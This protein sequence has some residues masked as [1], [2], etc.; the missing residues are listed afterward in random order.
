M[1]NQNEVSLKNFIQI[2]TGVDPLPVLQQLFLNDDLWDQHRM[3]TTF[4]GTPHIDVSDILLRFSPPSI[5]KREGMYDNTQP[6]W[7]A[8]TLA[9][10]PAVRPIVLAL[11]GRVGAFELG[12]TLI[13]KIKPGGQ[14][15]PHV[16]DE[17][18]YVH[19]PNIMR[20][21]VVLQGLP[22]SLFH[23]GDE[24]VC[25]KT[26]EVWAFNAHV[27]HAVVNNSADDRIHLI[28]DMT[29]WP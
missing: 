19:Q 2:A 12:R 5:T 26:G 3:R 6:V 15:L 22:G 20:Y 28:A 4:Q 13:T 1:T 10:L 25:M 9:K 11:M 18:E 17:G 7:Y 23:C 24:T 27:Q 8:D 21:H 14:I 29:L 16:D